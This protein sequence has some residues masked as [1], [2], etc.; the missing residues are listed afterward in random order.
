MKFRCDKPDRN[1]TASLADSTE[2]QFTIAVQDNNMQRLVKTD[3]LAA[4]ISIWNEF[5][6]KAAPYADEYSTL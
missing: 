4:T 3:P 2:S 5:G 1:L 6:D